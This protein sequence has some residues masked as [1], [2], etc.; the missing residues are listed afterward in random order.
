VSSLSGPLANSNALVGARTAVAKLNAGDWF[1]ATLPPGLQVGNLA[2]RFDVV[3]ADDESD[4]ELHLVLVQQ[5]L[6]WVDFFIAGTFDLV[7][8]PE[9][10]L[11]SAAGMIAMDCCVPSSDSYPS[12]EWSS[13]FTIPSGSDTYLQD[14]VRKMA[15]TTPHPRI[16]L[17]YNASSASMAQVCAG[18]PDLAIEAN[19]LSVVVEL[20][21]AQ[22]DL[23][24]VNETLATNACDV[25]IL[26][27]AFATSV[28]VIARLAPLGF[29]AMFALSGPGVPLFAQLLGP[30]AEYV[31]SAA[32]WH[33]AMRYRDALFGN[34]S[35]FVAQVAAY[36]GFQFQ[37]GPEAAGA[38]AA[39]HVLYQAIADVAQAGPKSA[40]Y[41][42]IQDFLTPQTLEAIRKQGRCFFPPRCCMLALRARGL[43][44]GCVASATHAAGHG[45]WSGGV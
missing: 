34:T 45:V 35:N 30:D 20:S 44:L 25:L 15:F 38:A 4:P 6:G 42:N 5:L 37:A 28:E 22:V 18:V 23:A 27:H 32:Q 13:V 21:S 3:Y 17:V 8:Q 31:T 9:G 24:Q 43:T 36:T 39:V 10:E 33:P 7:A 26:C 1:N 29:K 14:F 19:G 40:T 2:C 16:A 12:P 41:A 11:L